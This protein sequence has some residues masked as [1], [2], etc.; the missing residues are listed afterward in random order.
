[1]ADNVVTRRAV[2]TAANDVIYWQVQKDTAS[3]SSVGRTMGD[4]RYKPSTA[5]RNLRTLGKVVREP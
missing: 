4:R 1:M 2:P 5:P 3:D